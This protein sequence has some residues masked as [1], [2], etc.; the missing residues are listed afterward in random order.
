MVLGKPDEYLDCRRLF[1]CGVL[2]PFLYIVICFQ[3]YFLSGIFPP[4]YLS[5]GVVLLSIVCVGMGFKYVRLKI[6]MRK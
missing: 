6:K 5:I 4:L 3:G 2:I 1:W